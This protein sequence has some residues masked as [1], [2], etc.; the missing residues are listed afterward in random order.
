MRLLWNKIVLIPDPK[1][2]ATQ[3]KPTITVDIWHGKSKVDTTPKT[4]TPKQLLHPL[5]LKSLETSA[6]VVYTKLR[7]SMKALAL[8]SPLAIICLFVYSSKHCG[9]RV[10]PILNTVMQTVIVPG[11]EEYTE[12]S[13]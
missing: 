1:V 7:G 9:T 6:G 5:K 11:N 4:K 8:S 10:F 3:E 2:D 12:F 13:S